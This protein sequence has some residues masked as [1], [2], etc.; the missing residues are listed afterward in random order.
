MAYEQKRGEGSQV[1]KYQGAQGTHDDRAMSLVII[2]GVAV[3][4]PLFRF[5]VLQ[6]VIHEYE[7]SGAPAPTGVWVDI[8][9]ELKNKEQETSDGYYD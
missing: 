7:K 2:A 5:G 3:S 9:D 4:Y 1:T 8:H 6:S